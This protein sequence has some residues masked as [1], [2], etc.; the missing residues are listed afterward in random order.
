MSIPGLLA[1]AVWDA[2]GE[3]SAEVVDD[4]DASLLDKARSGVSGVLEGL[5]VISV[6][7]AVGLYVL[8]AASVAVVIGC[9]IPARRLMS[10]AVHH[11]Q[12]LAPPH[13]QYY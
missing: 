5:G 7:P 1:I 8:S 2:V 4:P 6:Q 12:P 11:G 3:T 10:P 9:L 13:Q